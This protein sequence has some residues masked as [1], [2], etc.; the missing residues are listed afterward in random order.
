MFEK[1]QVSGYDKENDVAIQLTTSNIAIALSQ[2]ETIKESCDNGHIVDADTGEVYAHFS[3]TTDHCGVDNHEWA[4]KQFIED[5][6][7]LTEYGCP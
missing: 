4:S 3:Y 1:F 7:E 2:Y 5:L 6:E